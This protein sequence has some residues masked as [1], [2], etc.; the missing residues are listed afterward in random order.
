MPA[1]RLHSG[2]VNHSNRRLSARVALRAPATV[3]L[4]GGQTR[5]VRMCDL[6]MDGASLISPRPIPQG[7]SLALRLELPGGAVV[8]TPARVVYSSYVTQN[9]FKIGLTF[10]QLDDVGAE[11]ISAFME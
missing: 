8:A 6:A 10:T 7:S 1:H 9:E 2:F 3:S 4:P 11:A 5:E